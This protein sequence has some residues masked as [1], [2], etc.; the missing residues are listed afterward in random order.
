MFPIYE[1]DFDENNEYQGMQA[2]SFV[3]SP[4]IMTDF[5]YFSN[6]DEK[7]FL[8]E[9]KRI[10]VSPLLIP[11]QLIY[12]R[13][14]DGTPYYIRWSEDVIRKIAQKYVK[15]MKQNVITVEHPMMDNPNLTY[16]ECAIDDVYMLKMWIVE[17][18]END[19]INTIYGYN[20]LPKGTLCVMYKV[21]NRSLWKKI[22]NGEVKG[23]SLEAVCKLSKVNFTKIEKNNMTL[24]EKITEFLNSISEEVKELEDVAKKDNTDSAEVSIRY[25]VDDDVFITVDSEGIARNGITMEALQQGEYLLADGN[26]LVVDADSK[27]VE[28]RPQEEATVE[29]P[30]EAPIAEEKVEEEMPIQEAAEE[31]KKEEATEDEPTEDVEKVD[32]SKEVEII[33]EKVEE[34]VEEDKRVEVKINESAYKIEEEVANHINTLLSEI[35]SKEDEIKLLQ[36]RIAE[37]EKSTPSSEPLKPMI[38]QSNDFDYDGLYERLNKR[39]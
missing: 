20:K 35:S 12:R 37:L 9:D 27:F 14:E 29:E 15:E 17:D 7:M 31:E 22:K 2:V 24:F 4:A 26:I 25:M 21:H 30:I 23:L 1:L 6:Q 39:R 34:D 38:N 11:N 16:N 19:P 8:Q 3:E 28:T 32:E 13:T 33:E 36:S 18:M 10:V 5:V